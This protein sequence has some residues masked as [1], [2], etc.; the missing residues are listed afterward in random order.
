MEQKN[1]RYSYSWVGDFECSS[2]TVDDSD[3]GALLVT[4]E[5][6]HDYSKV[7]ISRRFNHPFQVVWVNYVW[8]ES[9]GWSISVDILTWKW[10][11]YRIEYKTSS[12]FIEKIRMLIEFIFPLPL[13]TCYQNWSFVI[14]YSPRGSAWFTCKN[15][16]KIK[17]VEKRTET[18]WVLTCL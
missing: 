15:D 8:N 9:K 2:K 1:S 18:T 11:L 7:A 4:F 5:I 16:A 13:L 14:I 17:Q 3:T 6:Y 10:S 12:E